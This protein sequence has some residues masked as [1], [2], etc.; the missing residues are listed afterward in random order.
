MKK[1]LSELSK[2]SVEEIRLK[3][4]NMHP[5]DSDEIYNILF[6]TKVINNKLI[7]KNTYKLK[8]QHEAIRNILIDNNCVEYGDC[9][10]DDICEVVGLQPTTIY[11]EEKGGHIALL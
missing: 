10:I 7:L 6:T 8:A 5:I 4:H 11:S 1:L 2:L 3:I 9:I